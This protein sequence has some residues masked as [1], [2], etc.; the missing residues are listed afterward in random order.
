MTSTTILILLNAKEEF[1]QLFYN[2]VDNILIEHIKNTNNYS[3][4]YI[5][6]ISCQCLEELE[7]EHPGLLF[8]LMGKKTIDILEI[9]ENLKDDEKSVRSR[10]TMRSSANE[11]PSIDNKK[12]EL[13]SKIVFIDLIRFWIIQFNRRRNVLCF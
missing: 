7:T 12:I 8:P 9:K 5:R 13:E 4:I 6:Q 10:R 1:P 2:F 3:N 11:I